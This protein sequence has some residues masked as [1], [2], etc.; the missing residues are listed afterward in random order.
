MI[1]SHVRPRHYWLVSFP[2]QSMQ[3]KLRTRPQSM[4]KSCFHMSIRIESGRIRIRV[5]CKWLPFVSPCPELFCVWEGSL[6][7]LVKDVAASPGEVGEQPSQRGEVLEVRSDVRAHLP[8][9]V[10]APAPLGVSCPVRLLSSALQSP[11]KVFL[12]CEVAI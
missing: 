7:R 3:I 8:R 10:T 6:Q 9:Q 12:H 11:L 4:R 5:A 2:N 1:N